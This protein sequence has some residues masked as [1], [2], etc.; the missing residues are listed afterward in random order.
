MRNYC[1]DTRLFLVL[2]SLEELGLED[3]AELL[4]ADSTTPATLVFHLKYK[5][6]PT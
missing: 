5:T 6:P 3:G 2:G 4:V 1:W